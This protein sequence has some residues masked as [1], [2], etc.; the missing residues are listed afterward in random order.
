MQMFVGLG[1]PDAKDAGNHRDI[2]YVA[3]GDIGCDQGF[4]A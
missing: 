2:A 3:L 1:N 4:S